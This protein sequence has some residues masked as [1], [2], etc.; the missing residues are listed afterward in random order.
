MTES[1]RC[2]GQNSAIL[3]FP[4]LTFLLVIFRRR[5]QNVLGLLLEELQEP[6]RPPARGI[7]GRVILNPMTESHCQ[8]FPMAGATLR[9]QTDT[10]LN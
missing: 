1:I 6:S 8:G 5:L 3:L 10:H 4:S 7:P 9:P 2:Y